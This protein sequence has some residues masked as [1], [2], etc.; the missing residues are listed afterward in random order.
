MH[1]D[2]SKNAS[3]N[4]VQTKLFHPPGICSPVKR[5]NQCTDASEV[6]GKNMVRDEGLSAPDT[7]TYSSSTGKTIPEVDWSP[8][9][10]TDSRH[11]QPSGTVLSRTDT[12]SNI[13]QRAEDTLALTSQAVEK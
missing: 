4:K 1:R 2:P 12:S 6:T 10:N 11:F 13:V 9:I 3:Q 5:P 7:M 8:D